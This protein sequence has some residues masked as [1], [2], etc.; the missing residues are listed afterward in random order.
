[1]SVITKKKYSLGWDFT[2]RQDTKVEM[3]KE[4]AI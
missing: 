1:M 4:G 3:R 2:E